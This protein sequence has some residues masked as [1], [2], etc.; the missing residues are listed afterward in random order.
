V[1]VRFESGAAD[2]HS[3][4]HH[5]VHYHSPGL[6]TKMYGFPLFLTACGTNDALS[7]LLLDPLRV[8]FRVSLRFGGF[9]YWGLKEVTD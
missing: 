1:T 2:S 6:V 3:N 9:E 5:H 7:H 8:S 4:A